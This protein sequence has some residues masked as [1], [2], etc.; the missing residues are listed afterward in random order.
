VI[1]YLFIFQTKDFKN[2]GKFL[3][4]KRKTIFFGNCDSNRQALGEDE[5]D[6]DD[7]S[8]DDFE[9][10]D[11]DDDYLYDDVDDGL[12]DGKIDYEMENER[13]ISRINE[14]IQKFVSSCS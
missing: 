3:N 2:K 9:L 6:F 14:M 5:D 13:P 11:D 12:G 4:G 7:D 8:D 1:F 10:N